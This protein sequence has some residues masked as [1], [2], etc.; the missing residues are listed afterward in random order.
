MGMTLS[1]RNNRPI[2]IR[3]DKEVVEFKMGSRVPFL[4]DECYPIAVPQCPR[5]LCSHSDDLSTASMNMFHKILS[6][7]PPKRPW[8]KPGR[9]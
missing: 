4:D 5:S 2:L 9:S 3:R 7:L 6:L 1:G 8:T